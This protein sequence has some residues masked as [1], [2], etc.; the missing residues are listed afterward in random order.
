MNWQPERNPEDIIGDATW[1]YIPWGHNE[2][3][4]H[5]THIVFVKNNVLVKIMAGKSSIMTDELSSY[6]LQL[7]RDVARK[8]EAKIVAVLE[9]K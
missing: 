2:W 5:S 6:Q 7:A 4:Y 3:E 8:I 9:K 1:H